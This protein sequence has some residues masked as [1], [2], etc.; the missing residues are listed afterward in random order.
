MKQ[1]SKQLMMAYALACCVTTAGVAS[2]SSAEQPGTP[3]AATGQVNDAN[4]LVRQ[5]AFDQ[6]IQRYT[7]INAPADQRDTLNYNLAVAQ[8]RKGDL[9]A[10]E[11]LFAEAAKSADTA[12]AASSRYNLGNCDYAKALHAAEQDKNAAIGLLQRAINS[13]RSALRLNPDLVDARTNIELAGELI[14]KLREEQQQQ[15]QQKKQNQDQQQ[16]QQKNNQDQQQ[17]DQQQQD[18]SQQNQDQNAGSQSSKS[19]QP[20]KPEQDASQQQQQQQ[21][22]GSQ[23]QSQG[24]EDQQPNKQAP[25]NGAKDQQDRAGSDSAG[26][27]DDP[28]QPPQPGASSESSRQPESGQAGQPRQTSDAQHPP[29]PPHDQAQADR[30]SGDPE[31]S[32]DNKQTP[33]GE[34]T[35]AGEQ[36]GEQADGALAAAGNSEDGRLSQ[37]EAMKMLQAVRDRDMVR[38]LWQEQI[39][40]SRHVPVDRD[41]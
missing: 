7:Q 8:Y 27:Q 40:Q 9:D 19:D 28:Q 21:Q 33:T 17:K 34:L 26:P 41:W 16:E 6:A 12:V 5:G 13:Y 31:E 2:A 22:Q 11:A 29:Q 10:A 14:R 30:A 25:D 15:Q 1:T 20:K 39:E 23:N 35:A 24:S 4:A 37:E 18:Q 32:A 38:R 36:A 3:N